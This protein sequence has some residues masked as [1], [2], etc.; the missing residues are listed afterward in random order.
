[1]KYYIESMTYWEE[2]KK[3]GDICDIKS[4]K[5]INKENRNGILYPYFSSNGIDGYV[6]EYLY[7][8][9]NVIIA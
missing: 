6:N 9:N 3:M 4:G 8:E 2:S 7:D 5:P 1:M